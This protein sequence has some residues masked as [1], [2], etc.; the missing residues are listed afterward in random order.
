MIGM[1]IVDA[2]V[3]VFLRRSNEYPRRTSDLVPADREAPVELLLDEMKRAGVSKAV[4][5]QLNEYGEDH[6]YL[7]DCLRRFPDR[8]AGVGLIDPSSENPEDRLDD[9]V[10][11]YGIT[12]I[13]L[14]RLDGLKGDLRSHAAYDL[15]GRCGDLG[16]KICLYPWSGQLGVFKFFIEEFPDVTVIFDHLGMCPSNFSVDDLGRPRIITEIPPPTL[17]EILRLSRHENVYVKLSG[18]YACSH[19]PYPYPDMKPIYRD[20]YRAFGAERLMWA[21]DF[22]WIIDEPGYERLLR[23]LDFHLPDLKPWE[24]SA[25]MGENA[26]RIW[27]L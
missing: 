22:P 10:R 13:R 14:T 26:M 18:D 24:K 6:R 21:T 23:L 25:I 8:F 27:N 17:D 16:V 7:S 1:D 4:L 12:G 11:R 5:I 20:L 3:H 9:L 15:W 19:E 2:H